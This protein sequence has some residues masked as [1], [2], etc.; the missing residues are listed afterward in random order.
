MK[1]SELIKKV[2]NNF[3]ELTKSILLDADCYG[4]FIDEAKYTDKESFDIIL[5]KYP[6]IE[7][8]KLNTIYSLL[9]AYILIYPK[10]IKENNNQG[11]NDEN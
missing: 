3:Q 11:E 8:D 2:I 7:K 6:N 9:V 5:D 1:T 4:A 10:K